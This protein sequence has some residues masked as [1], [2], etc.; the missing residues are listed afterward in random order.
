M[1]ISSMGWSSSRRIL[2]VTL[3]VRLNALFAIREFLFTMPGPRF[4]NLAGQDYQ[5]YGWDIAE[6]T[7]QDV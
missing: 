5:R 4:L 6:K 2:R 1:G 7:L 3:K